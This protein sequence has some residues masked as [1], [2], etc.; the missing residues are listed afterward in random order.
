[1]IDDRTPIDQRD[2]DRRSGDDTP[3]LEVT[4]RRANDSELRAQAGERGLGAL[5]AGGV[6]L[7][8]LLGAGLLELGPGLADLRVHGGHFGGGGRVG[9]G[10]ES[11]G[12]EGEGTG[13]HVGISWGDAGRVASR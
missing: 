5:D 2:F 7:G 12:E 3:P 9:S 13:K 11:E 8:L 1:V 10:R 4:L 6:A